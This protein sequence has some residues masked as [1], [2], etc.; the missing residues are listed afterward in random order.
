MSIAPLPPAA[1]GPVPALPSLLRGTRSCGALVRK[2]PYSAACRPSEP[3]P[4]RSGTKTRHRT[5]SAPSGTAMPG[6]SFASAE[7]TSSAGRQRQYSL[8]RHARHPLRNGDFISPSP[9]PPFSVRLPGLSAPEP[10]GMPSDQLLT[11]VNCG[12]AGTRVL[13]PA[14]LRLEGT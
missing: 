4:R 13:V 2:P 10:A 1:K 3:R 9:P 8:T 7:T 11:T 6:G 12:Q 14:P 5:A